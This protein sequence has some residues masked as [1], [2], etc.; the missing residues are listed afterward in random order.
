MNKR[1]GIYVT[2]LLAYWLAVLALA[3]GAKALD[4]LSGAIAFWGVI[5]LTLPLGPIL[6]SVYLHGA[7]GDFYS[8]AFVFALINSCIFGGFVGWLR[9]SRQRGNSDSIE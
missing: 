3:W 4:G 2:L 6:L 8:M 7:E 1:Y 9:T 5:V